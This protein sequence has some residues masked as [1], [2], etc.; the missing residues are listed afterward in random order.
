MPTHSPSSSDVR[1]SCV[2]RRAPRPA[3]VG[4]Q[5]GGDRLLGRAVPGVHHGVRLDRRRP[6]GVGGLGQLAPGEGVDL[7][8]RRLVAEAPLGRRR[9]VHAEGVLGRVPAV[10]PH[11]PALA[12]ALAQLA[13]DGGDGV[14][15]VVVPRTAGEGE[16]AGAGELTLD[17]EPERRRPELHRRREARVQVDDVDVVDADA[18]PATGPARRRSRSPASGRTCPGWTRTRCSWQSVPAWGKT[19]RSSAH[20]VGAGPL[21]GRHDRR[22]RPCRRRCWSSCTCG[23]GAPIIRLLRRDRR[24]SP[25]AS[26][27]PGSTRSGCRRRRR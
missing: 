11:Q 23:T 1:T 12:G 2:A 25:R 24:R 14:H 8:L 5:A 16:A 9:R 17:V 15:H 19:Q 7:V 26:W 27:R 3:A 10:G 18:R 13:D 4:Q 21:D 20:A 6:G 22:R